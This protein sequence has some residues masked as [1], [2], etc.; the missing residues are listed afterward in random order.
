MALVFWGDLQTVTAGPLTFNGT[1]N[2]KDSSGETGGLFTQAYG[3]NFIEEIDLNPAMSLSGSARYDYRNNNG[4]LR[5]VLSPAL[6]YDINNDIFRFALYGTATKTMLEN[7]VGT[8]IRSWESQLDN[9]WDDP[10]LPQIQISF[11]QTSDSDDLD[12]HQRDIGSTFGG[13][14]LEWEYDTLLFFYSYYSQNGKDRAA[15]SSNSSSTHLV[16]ADYSRSF[17]RNRIS[18]D[19]SH[20]YN[21]V[22]SEIVVPVGA[23]NIALTP[24]QLPAVTAGVDVTPTQTSL[25][26]AAPALIDG[27]LNTVA[28]AV[29]P[30]EV[31]NIVMRSDFQAIDLVYLYTTK[32]LGADAANLS[33]DTY[34]SRDGLLWTLKEMSSLPRY[35]QG[36]QRFEIDLA[37]A[38]DLFVKLVVINSIPL[39]SVEFAEIAGFRKISATGAYFANK[40][41]NFF[42]LTDF[43]TNVKLSRSVQFAY[44]LSLKDGKIA[45]GIKQ[46]SLDH[47]SSLQWSPGEG[48]FSASLSGSESVQDY[49]NRPLLGNRSFGVNISSQ[50]LSTL[51]VNLAVVRAQTYEEKELIS[52]SKNYSFYSN[53]TILPDLKSSFNVAYSEGRIQSSDRLNTNIDSRLRLTALLF[54]GLEVDLIGN[55]NQLKTDIETEIKDGSFSLSWRVSD[56]LSTSMIV[57]KTWEDIRPDSVDLGF[58]MSLAVTRKNQVSVTYSYEEEREQLENTSFSWNWTITEAFSLRSFGSYLERKPLEGEELKGEGV[59]WQIGAELI[60]RSVIWE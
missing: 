32:D 25:F 41:D 54:P 11:G 15:D 57:K 59:A 47:A 22:N 52:D 3:I 24:V 42:Q 2:Y 53:A 13:A 40:Q 10:K 18:V 6:S 49:D 9:G 30:N 27:D 38:E 43:N 31:M 12:Q 7:G 5:Q 56:I 33:W 35:D 1:W 58:S 55:Y 50:L 28:L 14:N 39:K 4:Q 48:R 20:Q 29:E 16:R 21:I 46:Y 34:V 44:N 36:F 23:G 37:G 17:W 19:L 26:S 60:M 8:T 45:D 51:D